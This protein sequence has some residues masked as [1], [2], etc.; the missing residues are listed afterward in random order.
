MRTLDLNEAADMLRMHPVTLA[1]R[2]AAG[3]IPGA[4]IGKRWIFIDEDLFEWIRSKY[5]TPTEIK[6]P[7]FQASQVTMIAPHTDDEL[8]RLLAPTRKARQARGEYQR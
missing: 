5:R 7:L 1:E 8:D 6:P 4:K 2:A 3:A